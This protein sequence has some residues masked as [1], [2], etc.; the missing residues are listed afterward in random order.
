MEKWKPVSGWKGLYEVSNMG[1]VR[2]LPRQGKYRMYGGKVLIPVMKNG[3]HAISLNK[4]R[5][6]H[7]EYVH[8]LVLKAFVGEPPSA[9]YCTNHKNGIRIDNRPENL[10]WVTYAENSRHSYEVL[11]NS[12]PR[13]PHQDQP[14]S[15]AGSKNNGAKLTENDVLYI[16]EQCEHSYYWGM[17]TEL[18][19]Q[20]DVSVGTISQIVNRKYWTHI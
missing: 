17:L 2:S 6:G 18:A 13:L 15:Q 10:E 7:V 14:G 20:F 3:Y 8:R 9:R 19:K 5:R 16:R 1:R 11:G 4:N 12:Y